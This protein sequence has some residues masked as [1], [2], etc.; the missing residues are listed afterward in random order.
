MYMEHLVNMETHVI[1]YSAVKYGIFI[2]QIMIIYIKGP[3]TY[4]Y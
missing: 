4:K 3:D 1:R 2:N